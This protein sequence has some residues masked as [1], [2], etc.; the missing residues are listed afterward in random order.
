M[1]DLGWQELMMV[2]F[3][4]VLVVGPKDLPRVLRAFA[5]FI[6][7]AR[8]MATEFQSSMMEV[9]NQDEFKDVKKALQDAK[10]GNF[11]DIASGL[12]G[13]KDTVEDIKNESG[14]VESVESIKATAQEIEDETNMVA[15]E[16]AVAATTKPKAVKA[17]PKTSSKASSSRTAAKKKTAK[18]ASKAAS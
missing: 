11:D 10:S 8:G 6:G 16:A 15:D 7:K 9:A 3:V 2:A 12:D 18:K 4:L 17:S 1:L 5:K 13:M 14:I